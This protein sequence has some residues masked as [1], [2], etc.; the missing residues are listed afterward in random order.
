MGSF[1]KNTEGAF[2]K[3]FRIG[4]KIFLIYMLYELNLF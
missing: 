2:V 4:V 3:E 1:C